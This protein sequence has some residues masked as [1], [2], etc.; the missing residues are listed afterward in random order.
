MGIFTWHAWSL[1]IRV[2]QCLKE[3]SY[4]N[5]VADQVHPVMLMVYP[6]GDVYFQ[7]DNTSCQSAT[8]VEDCFEK[9]E[10]EFNL[11]RWMTQSS[12]LNCIENFVG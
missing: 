2:Q 9:R 12:D 6:N 8:I 1:T 5:I 4:P 7:Q 10:R 3:T 11:L